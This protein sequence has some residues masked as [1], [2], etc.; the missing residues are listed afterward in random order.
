MRAPP[1]RPIFVVGSGRSGTTWIGDTLASA[2][3]CC[4]LF[5]PLNARRVPEVPAWGHTSGLPGPYLR[6]D[7]SA[8]PWRAFYERLLW[9]GISNAWIRQDD[10][11]VLSGLGRLPFGERIGYRL[12]MM[13]YQRAE[14]TC[15][16]YVVKEIR[17][18]LMLGWLS[19]RF[20][21]RVVFVLR[22]PCAVV[23]SRLR[24]GWEADMRDVLSQANLMHDHLGPCRAA[25]EGAAT[26]LQRQAVLWCVENL[27]PLRLAAQRPDW[28]LCT[29]ED[30]VRDPGVFDRL[31][32]ALALTA[33]P[34]TEE[35]RRQLVSNPD[36]PPDR[37]K[38]WHHPLRE[39]EAEEVLRICQDFGIN[40]YGKQERPV[41]DPRHP[42]ALRDRGVPGPS[43]G[44]EPMAFFI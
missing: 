11:R 31:F 44:P 19:Q 29:Y 18:N 5:E 15:A 33:G 10:D 27:V 2:E 42:L 43:H 38:P 32:R 35:V 36:A 3:G 22:H 28:L 17:A 7:E 13:R 41:C 16:R 12:A 4:S 34:A 24:L 6:P 9:G 37:E 20:R 14:A 23:G 39:A 8:Q 30:C 25:I 1:E 21:V 26:P 40:V